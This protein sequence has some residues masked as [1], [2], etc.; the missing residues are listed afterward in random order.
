ME[1]ESKSFNLS[2][3]HPR[4]NIDDPEKKYLDRDISAHT[5][6][7]VIMKLFNLPVAC[8]RIPLLLIVLQA[9][10]ISICSISDICE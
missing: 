2:L 8:E 1:Y 6:S 5:A 10:N 9:K 7:D 4:P 3:H